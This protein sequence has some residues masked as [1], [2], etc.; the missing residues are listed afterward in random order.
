MLPSVGPRPD[1]CVQAVSP[2]VTFGYPPGGRLP[3]HSNRLAVTPV[4]FTRWRHTV[5]HPIPAYY[6]FVDPKKDERL[7]WRD[8]LTY[9]CS[10][11]FIRNSGHP[12]AAGQAQ[13]R[14]SSPIRDRC[15]TTVPRNQRKHVASVTKYQS[16]TLHNRY[17]AAVTQDQC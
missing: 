1:P 12:S 8:W 14:E 13:D 15:S 2:Q 3:V 11:R 6:L 16:P 4:A 9:T 10:G 7:R 5:A 17:G